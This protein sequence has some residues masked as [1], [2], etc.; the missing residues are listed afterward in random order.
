MLIFACPRIDGGLARQLEDL[1]A[2]RA[3][4]HHET[5]QPL[6]W[7]GTLRRHAHASSIESSTS[8]EGFSVPHADAVAIVA[9]DD[10]PGGDENRLAVACYARA[11]EHVGTMALD[12][13]FEWSKRVLLDLHFDACQFQ[14]DK[15]PGRWRQGPVS[16]VGGDGEIAYRAPDAE[17]VPALMTEVADWLEQGDPDAHV[18]VRA[19]MAHLHMV[20]VHP[21]RDG[22]GR[23]ARIV[24]SLVLA[25]DGLVS[26]ELASIEEHLG[27]HTAEY[28]AALA[29]VQGG[30][31]LPD[32]DARPWIEFCLEAHLHSARRRLGQI[33]RAADRWARL[34]GIVEARG[35]PDRLVI[36]LE[37]SLFGGSDRAAYGREADV[38]PATASTDFRR[39]L[40]AG[41]VEQSGRGPSSRYAAS[42]DLLAAVGRS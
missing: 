38:S 31:Y 22:N 4:L 3:R 5:R 6:R 20:T 33:E 14:R 28:Y 10:P 16:V 32:R 21:Y 29:T 23:V 12:P 19:A 15:G 42:P 41:L 34:E 35:W 17:E 24:Q 26:P 36:A 30:S 18:V 37:Q 39:L 9:G 40:D 25:R 2:L 7:I 1:D 27:Q 8:I 11:M 13:E